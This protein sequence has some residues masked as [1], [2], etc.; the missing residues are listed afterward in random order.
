VHKN[1]IERINEC[2]NE[3][4]SAEQKV[5]KYILE[6]PKDIIHFSITELADTSGVSE[7]TVFRLCNRLGYKGYQ[8]L[9]INLAGDVVTQIE[10]IHEEI[11]EDDNMY[12]IMNKIMKSNLNSIETTMKMNSSQEL[13]KAVELILKSKQ[14]LFFGMGGS[15]ALALDGYHKFI[16]TGLSCVVHTDSH[17]Q[18]MAASMAQENDT[19]IAFSN[20]GSNK[21]LV[22]NLKIAKERGLNIISITSNKKS[23]IA[24]VSDVVLIS[25]AKEL[26]FRSEAMESRISAL[27]LLDCLYIAVALRRKDETLRT[28]GN[29]RE[30]IARKRY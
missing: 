28:L 19:V 8:E 29:I 1:C 20:S 11:E 4:K 10:N 12:L 26:L 21:E 27:T 15:G 23:P 13:E 3:L 2:Y 17:W 16:R 25:Y 9:K 14:L 7:T 6:N 30:G 24:K 22:E 5:A 18:A